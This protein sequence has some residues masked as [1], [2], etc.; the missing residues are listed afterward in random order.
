MCKTLKANLKKLI[1]DSGE[2][3]ARD[4]DGNTVYVPGDITYKDWYN[5]FVEEV[6]END[7]IKKNAA[8]L[9]NKYAVIEPK[10]TKDLMHIVKNT[11]GKLEGLEYKLNSI[12]SLE[13]KIKSDTV[14][15]GGDVVK[16]IANIKDVLRYTIV[17]DDAVFT[18]GYYK[19]V[20]YLRKN[21]YD[22]VR[23]KNTFV[24]KA[25]YKG[26][27]ALFK[28]SDGNVFELQFHTPASFDVKNNELHKLYERQRTLDKSKDRLKI[29]QLRNKMIKISAGVENPKNVERI[30]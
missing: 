9:I 7:V 6:D 21:G 17:R 26:I 29:K 14:E 20:E 10:I 8:K 25:P 4:E 15:F 1:G 23:L 19:T 3:A 24:D 18:D 2:R 30:K 27:N 5:Q 16:A 12:D 22:I 11:N 28:D 13:R